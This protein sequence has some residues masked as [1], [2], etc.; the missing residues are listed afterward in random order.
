MRNFADV[1]MDAIDAKQSRLVVGL[2]PR[3]EFVPDDLREPAIKAAGS[4]CGAA[5]EMLLQFNK[6]VID[7]VAAALYWSQGFHATA[8]LFI[9]YVVIAVRG[10][11][12]WRAD[13]ARHEAGTV[14][15]A[16]A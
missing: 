12:T 14:A 3:I 6:I 10:Y 15:R 1:L 13:L 9:I 5:A 8:V 7:I 4:Y 16:D 2:D 11:L